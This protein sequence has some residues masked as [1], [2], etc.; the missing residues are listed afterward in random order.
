LTTGGGDVEGEG[1]HPPG[2]VSLYTGERVKK[3]GGHR[4]GGIKKG[5]SEHKNK[6]RENPGKKCLFI[7]GLTKRTKRK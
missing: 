6:E 3:K 5:D 7:A 4:E 1:L 2:N